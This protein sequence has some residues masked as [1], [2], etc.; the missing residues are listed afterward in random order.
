M[1]EYYFDIET[2]GLNFDNDEIIT[3][4]WQNLDGFTGKPVGELNILKRW[5]SSEKEIIETFLPNLVC[6]PFDFIF[7]GKNLLFD[8][9]MLN[10]RLKYFNLGEIDLKC[11]T[12]RA[13]I[14]IKPILVM[15]NNGNFKGHSK[16]FPKT[17][18]ITNDLIPELFRERK[19]AEIIQYIIDE[20]KDFLYAYQ[21]LKKELP[22]LKE[23]CT[24][25]R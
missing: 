20:A 8:F 4:Q 2:T 19:Y 5:D 15:M 17:N 10:E 25:N 1:V 11:L 12:Q 22:L 23:R 13:S 7:V 24:Q 16:I 14:D 21:I 3:I 6:K 9:C 18:P